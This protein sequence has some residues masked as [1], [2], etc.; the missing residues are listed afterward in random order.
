MANRRIDL[1]LDRFTAVVKAISDPNRV[2]VL[3][4]LRGRELC[5]C[6]IVELLGL[7]GSTVSK[8]LFLLKQAG[9]VGSRKQG[10]WIHY[11]R[12]SHPADPAIRRALEWI[13][14]SL[15][16]DAKLRGD[17]KR[18]GEILRIPVETLCGTG[19]RN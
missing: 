18:L 14:A 2:R 13:D 7:A 3:A 16:R 15:A 12:P 10:K 17:R 8:H 1:S 11:A 19:K 6:Q 9:L 4:A 5:V